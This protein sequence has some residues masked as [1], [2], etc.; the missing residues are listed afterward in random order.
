[1]VKNKTKIIIPI[2]II[3]L[4]LILF[5]LAFI[6]IPRIPQ[7]AI[8]GSCFS[9]DEGFTNNLFEC[10]N[11][12]SNCKVD[13]SLDCTTADTARK[14]ILRLSDDSKAPT[15]FVFDKDKNGILRSYVKEG[16]QS[17][18]IPS[19]N[20][21]RHSFGRSDIRV[22]DNKVFVTY[23]AS[24]QCGRDINA[25]V[26]VLYESGG[27]MP[28]DSIPVQGYE[29]REY[30]EG[31]QNIY[32]CR[33][34]VFGDVTLELAYS[35]KE[36]GTVSETINLNGGQSINWVGRINYEN[37]FTFKSECTR[38]MPGSSPSSYKICEL[39]VNGC[40][41]FS[42]EEDCP[43]GEYYIISKDE[44]G[45][46]YSIS[47][48][49]SK[50]LFK[51]TEQIN[52]LI[53]L[54]DTSKKSNINIEVK[55]I[56]PSGT[57]ISSEIL[58]TDSR[59]ELSFSFSKQ[60]N[61]G[62]YKINVRTLSHPEGDLTGS[63]YVQVGECTKSLPGSSS[64]TYYK[65]T[66]KNGVG[67]LDDFESICISGFFIE[68]TG[69]CGTPYSLNIIPS[70]DLFAVNSELKGRIKLTDTSNRQYVEIEVKLYNQIN[71]LKDTV[72]ITTDSFGEA[73]F[74]LAG[75][76][77][78]G[79]Y[80][81]KART[82]NHP[83]GNLEKSLSL[84][85]AQPIFINLGFPVGKDRKQFVTLPIEITVEVTG[86]SG[87]LEN[88]AN[89]DFTGTKCGGIS[90]AHKV[91]PQR[92]S[93]GY[94]LLKTEIDN[95]CQFVYQVVAIDNS[96]FKSEPQ[97]INI[98]VESAEIIIQPDLVGMNFKDEGTYTIEFKTFDAR[99]QPLATDSTVIIRDSDGCVSGE[100]CYI[101]SSFIPPVE[102]TGGYG[103]Y[104]FTH[105][106][107]DGLSTISITSDATGILEKTQD[108]TVTLYR[109][110]IPGDDPDD[111]NEFPTT[112]VITIAVVV[113]VLAGFGFIMFKK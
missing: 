9:V 6:F 86:A 113:L 47:I 37:S 25:R 61:A 96:G 106:F 32:N 5:V 105:L 76:P 31:N 72:Y 55:L 22:K 46:P 27:Y 18:N 16:S 80:T 51:S 44:C 94:Y 109:S 48:L 65:C 66:I 36:A 111:P 41:Y 98:E 108:F 62:R 42:D 24:G 4:V 56:S 90:Y 110:S 10:P 84:N 60:S 64:K 52:G 1:M 70:E 43:E 7:S 73:K 39:D 29:E 67:S 88:V 15:Q 78:S 13:I 50:T 68:S 97:L 74:S 101:T 35:E 38:N 53:K 14:V 23:P 26:S 71:V 33:Q 40:G 49:P 81:V 100:Y 91:Q 12:A 102:V 58:K 83:E 99:L 89:W 77:T 103:T 8:Q 93:E 75:Q 82:L 112:I 57:T 20:Y 34:N 59:G 45:I 3:S 2:S 69:T 92:I 107:K 19:Y 11:D 54:R 79:D 85:V 104:S 30:Y 95:E 21:I 28:T 87:E 17:C 63:A